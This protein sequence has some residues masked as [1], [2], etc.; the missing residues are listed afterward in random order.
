MDRSKVS[1]D[2]KIVMGTPIAKGKNI[3]IPPKSADEKVIEE[4]EIV[5]NLESNTKELLDR[6]NASKNKNQER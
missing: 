3:E 1:G 5:L 4:G 6:L 2:S